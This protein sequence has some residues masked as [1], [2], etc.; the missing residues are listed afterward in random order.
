M[1]KIKAKIIRSLRGAEHGASTSEIAR[2]TGHSR[3]TVAKYLEVMRV[4]GTIDCRGVGRAKLWSLRKDLIRILAVDDEPHITSLLG[5]LFASDRYDV[6]KAGSAAEARR[7]LL[8]KTPD[9]ILLDLM[10][11]GESG[12]SLLRELRRRPDTLNVPVIILSAKSEPAE[13]VKGLLGGAD[14]YITKP[15]DPMELAARAERIIERSRQEKQLNHITRLPGREMLESYLAGHEGNGSVHT[16]R[17]LGIGEYYGRNGIVRGDML[18]CL[19]ARLFKDTLK[20]TDS[21]LSHTEQDSFA[22]VSHD[23]RADVLIR[24]AFER[25]VPML[26][27]G[28]ALEHKGPDARVPQKPEAG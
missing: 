4:E 7:I 26:A 6:W 13:K 21:Y 9:L 1:E 27:K 19:L 18:L 2:S 16:Y 22:V 8:D 11:P 25:V 3:L 14:D 10:M 15:F 5:L 28:L 12:Y 24:Q 17:V 20:N 23:G